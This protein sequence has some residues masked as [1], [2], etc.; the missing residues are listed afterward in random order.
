MTYSVSTDLTATESN[1][2]HTTWRQGRLRL[3]HH[4]VALL[5]MTH[6]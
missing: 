1:N 6:D 3:H 2:P 4:N 5:I